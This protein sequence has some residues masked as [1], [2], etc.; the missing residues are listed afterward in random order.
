MTYNLFEGILLIV[1]IVSLVI[2]IPIHMINKSFVLLLLV[3]I[4]FFDFS[5]LENSGWEIFFKVL[6]LIFGLIFINSTSNKEMS[7]SEILIL[8]VALAS[9]LMVSASNFLALYLCLELQSLSIFILIGR[10]RNSINKIEASLKYFVLSSISSGLFL[11]GSALIFVTTGSCDFI[12]FSSE[13]AVVEGVLVLIALLFKLAASPFHFW[14]P[15][16]YQGSDNR[17]LL[18]LGVLPKISVFSILVY[19]Y[20]HNKLILIA[21]VLSLLIGCVGAI[22]Q[23]ILKRLLGYSS[24]L[25]IGFALL[26]FSLGTFKGYEGSIIYLVIYLITFCA[27]IIAFRHITNENTLIVELSNFLTSNKSVTMIFALCIL[28]MAGIPPLGGFL[29]KWFVLSAAINAGLILV[30][31]LSI[32]CAMIAG[33]YYLRLVKITYFEYGKPF[34][35]WKKILVSRYDSPGFTGI[36]LGVISYFLIFLLLLPQL[37]FHIAHSGTITLF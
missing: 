11:L 12:P 20:P 13:G 22:N 8:S 2:K 6:C 16:V 3:A 4:L 33:V 32:L 30:S 5:Q 37:V 9:S 27:I 24:I 15:D 31:I 10:K 7:S 35:M 28:S 17:S 19:M 18:V 29:A 21:T 36:I 26:S 34:L 1:L 14:T 23:S 25:A